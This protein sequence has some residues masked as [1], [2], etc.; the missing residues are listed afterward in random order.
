MFSPAGTHGRLS[1]TIFHRVLERPDPS[2]PSLPDLEQ[3]DRQLRWLKSAFE[4]LPLGPAI[5]RLRA[6]TLPA[7]AA[8]IT[9]DDGY[10]DN[11]TCALPM[12]QR[13]GLHATFFISTGYLDGAVMWNDILAAAIH[14]SQRAALDATPAGQGMIDL[15][16]DVSARIAIEDRLNHAVK[17]LPFDERARVV[18][19]LRRHAGVASPSGLMMSRAQLHALHRAGMGIGAHTVS[20]PI[21]ARC[22]PE[23]AWREITDGAEALR[24]ELGT[25][26][27]LFAYPNGRPDLDYTADHVRMV[28]D[29]GF[30]AAVTTATGAARHGDDL[31]QLPRF[32]P[33]DRNRWKYTARLL[34]NL[35]RVHAVAGP[36]GSALGR[37]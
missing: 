26:I 34:Q 18:D 11:V 9:F 4:V 30:A 32:T 25:A 29:A 21:L 8:A 28:R 23:Q 14:R 17:H 36:A 33:W 1:I 37:A 24:C 31:Y 13:H 2:S 5:E 27:E 19:A 3:F 35:R 7:R 15:P 20:H 12:L 10:A 22:E 6:G 16:A